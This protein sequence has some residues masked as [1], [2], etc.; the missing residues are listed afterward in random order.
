[1]TII[2]HGQGPTETTTMFVGAD[3][4]PGISTTLTG[5]TAPSGIPGGR[6]PSGIGIDR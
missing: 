6:F 3:N 1:M 5:D 2:I 4:T